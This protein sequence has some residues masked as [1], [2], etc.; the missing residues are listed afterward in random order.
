LI[1]L[2]E[3]L[4]RV[5]H[6]H[7][8]NV[9]REN[10]GLREQNILRLLM[11]VGVGSSELDPVWL[12]DATSFSEDR[13]QAAHRS[14]SVQQIPDPFIELRRV[15]ALARGLAPIDKRLVALRSV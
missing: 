10:H 12:A 6:H 13:G 5:R 1:S 2:D 3:R 14:G 11:P 15:G 7:V 9:V 4:D 8:G